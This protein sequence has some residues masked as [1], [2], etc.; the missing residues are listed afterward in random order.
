MFRIPA[1]T[2]R[3]R[4]IFTTNPWSAND[5][6]SVILGGGQLNARKYPID[7]EE[8]HKTI[9][10]AVQPYTITSY[11]RVYALIE[12]VRYVLANNI[13]GDFV[14]CGVYKG[15]STMAMAL[16]LLTEGSSD[17]D[18][19][20][21]DTFEGMPKPGDKDVDFRGIAAIDTFNQKKLT[22]TSSSWVN[23]SIDEVRRAMQSTEYP[24]DRLH[25]VPGLVEDTI[26]AHAPDNNRLV[27]SRY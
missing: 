21:F 3:F 19:H 22:D 4:R 25:F 2:G 5:L 27:A 15:G 13:P 26:P 23:A 17:R 20:L 10:E 18:I 11:L 7:F 9:I 24:Q 1:Q 12:A 6:R 16:T 8:R 14:E